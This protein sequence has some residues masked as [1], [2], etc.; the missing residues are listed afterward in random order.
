MQ[1]HHGDWFDAVPKGQAAV[2]LIVSNPP[3]IAA[4]EMLSLAPE[5]TDYE[6]RMALTDEGDG[7]EAYRRITAGAGARLVGGGWLR[8][9]IGPTQGEA[10]AGMMRAQGFASVS[11]A[12]D[13]D[14]RDRV[15]SGQKPCIST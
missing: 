5:V 8:V 9:E 3:Y 11:V 6:P 4:D 2:D 13:L 15:V 14:G 1:F 7:L 10:V 12:A